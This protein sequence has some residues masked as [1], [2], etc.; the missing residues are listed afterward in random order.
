MFSEALRSEESLLP[1][2]MCLW[3]PLPY[4]NLSGWLSWTLLR[5]SDAWKA[6]RVEPSP[7][8]EMSWQS[9]RWTA[10]PPASNLL[11]LLSP[12][13]HTSVHSSVLHISQDGLRRQAT[14]A[15]CLAWGTQ[16]SPVQLHSAPRG[17][18]TH[19]GP[20]RSSPAWCVGLSPLGCS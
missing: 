10:L 12:N 3:P 16:T 9:Q 18:A 15:F 13:T 1:P 11:S 14:P 8:P 19:P 5:Q 20:S 2:P 6:E 4:L 17:P 7:V